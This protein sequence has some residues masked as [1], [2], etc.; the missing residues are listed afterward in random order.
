MQKNSE[1]IILGID[2]GTNLM[3]YG[4]IKGFGNSPGYLDMGNIDLKKVTDPYMKLRVIHEKTVDLIVLGCSG[5]KGL[6]K[7]LLG[8]VSKQVLDDTS[9]SVLI[10]K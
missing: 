6:E 7:L 4:V 9:K 5:K 8:S 10:I 1:R 2:P 3:G